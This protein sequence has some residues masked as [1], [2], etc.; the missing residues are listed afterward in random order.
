MPDP[1]YYSLAKGWHYMIKPGNSATVKLKASLSRGGYSMAEMLVVVAI[2]ALMAA[3]VIPQFAFSQRGRGLK[4]GAT[5]LMSSLRAA[6]REAITERE[7]RALAI[8]LH[9]I[10]GE[11]FI[12]R[13]KGDDDP[14]GSLDWIQVGESHKLP[15]NI[16]IVAVLDDLD[17]SQWDVRRTDDDDLDGTANSGTDQ[18]DPPIFNPDPGAS[19][20][21]NSIYR[22]IRFNPTGTADGASIYLWN[23][24]DER[25]ENPNPSDNETLANLH[26]VGVPPGLRLD[27]SKNQTTFFAVWDDESQYDNYYYTIVVNPITGGVAV[28]DYA[29]RGGWDRKKDGG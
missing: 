17:D 11:F 20:D 29:W 16:A 19:T 7:L 26:T 25:G 9:S 3:I 1:V 23:I 10:P 27:P 21:V 28:Y 18:W 8:D 2:I 13:E 15:D 12:M 24:E 14:E 4:G 6:R 5:E 22:L